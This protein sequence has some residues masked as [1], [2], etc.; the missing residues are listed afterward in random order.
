MLKIKD[1]IILGTAD[2]GGRISFN[3]SERIL[4]IFLEKYK[5]IQTSTNYP[6]SSVKPF[7]DTLV[8]LKNYLDRNS[9][10]SNLTINIGSLSNEYS[11]NNDLTPTFFYA[12][13][14]IFKE[15]FPNQN[16]TL[17][18][19]WDDQNESRSDLLDLFY[20]IQNEVKIGLSGIRFPFNYSSDKIR[21]ECQVN[22]YIDKQTNSLLSTDL[23]K[24]LKINNMIG[25]QILGGKK[26]ELDR[27]NQLFS[28]YG[29]NV[30]VMDN[31]LLLV[32]KENLSKY[33]QVII[34]PKNIS[35][36]ISWLKIMEA[37]YEN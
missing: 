33:D 25:Y 21:Y 4:N 37:L 19:H 8:F 22:S 23:K 15:M 29:E 24:Y 1:K 28:L 26:I 20:E 3:E 16:L 27:M 32:L 11:N 2:F 10:V 13:F 30:K 14:L 35:Q 12:N 6:M 5:S 31:L 34:G 18:V 7:G 17:A 36:A 9:I